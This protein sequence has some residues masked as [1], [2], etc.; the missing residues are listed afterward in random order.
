MINVVLVLETF[1]AF[2][3]AVSIHECAHAAMASVL[4]DDTPANDGRLSFNP[5]RHLAPIGTLVAA[6]LSFGFG[7]LGYTGIGWGKPVRLNAQRL[8][9][10]PDVG[11]IIV[12]LAG[13]LAN[14]LLGVAVVIGL[15]FVPNFARLAGTTSITDGRC[16]ITAYTGRDLETCLAYLQPAGVLRL[17]QFAVVFAV[18]SVLIAIV[19][20]LPLYPLDCYKIIYSL[21]PSNPALAL[22]RYEPYMEAILLVIFFV[23]PILLQFMGIVVASPATLLFGLAERVVDGAAGG[24][25]GSVVVFLRYL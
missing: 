17:E 10:G 6:V 13:P 16:P 25:A 1:I 14:L 23:V 24:A 20:L 8:R 2:V 18:T 12:A 5:T 15:R 7:G 11:T 9:G 19:N 4:G 21:L 22:R 3:I